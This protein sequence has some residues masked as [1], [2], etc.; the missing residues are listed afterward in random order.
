MKSGC[1]LL[2]LTVMLCGLG[3]AYATL[4]ITTGVFANTTIQSGQYY[5]KGK[6]IICEFLM[7]YV[8]DGKQIQT[9]LEHV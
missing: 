7:G 3:C 4:T 8:S 5:W 1:G 9:D 6:L 2:I